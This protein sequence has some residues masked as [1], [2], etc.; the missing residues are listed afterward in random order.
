MQALLSVSVSSNIRQAMNALS[1]AQ[2]KVLPLATAKALTFAAEAGQ[3]AIKSEMQR[4]FDRP[5]PYTMNSTWVKSATVSNPEALVYLKQYGGKGVSADRYLLPEID[6]GSRRQ[7]S[8]ERQLAPLMQGNRFWVPAD[9]AKRDGYGNVPG[10]VLTQMLSQ[11]KVSSDAY[12]NQTKG[13]R[14]KGRR[15]GAEQY[16]IPSAGSGLRPGIYKHLGARNIAPVLIFTAHA[17]YRPRLAFY[18]VGMSAAQEAF[19]AKLAGQVE[20][21]LARLLPH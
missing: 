5:T 10:Q 6:G 15:R 17:N 20:R 12:Q 7:K 8:S 13:S 16:F 3:K 1:Q 11:L 18:R 4:V 9:L 19:P 2:Q 21:E 14:A